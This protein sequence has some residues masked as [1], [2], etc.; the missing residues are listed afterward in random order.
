MSPLGLSIRDSKRLNLCETGSWADSPAPA[1]PKGQIPNG[2]L[3]CV[4]P[5]AYKQG[6]AVVSLHLL[7]YIH[8]EKPRI[9]PLPGSSPWLKVHGDFEVDTVGDVGAGSKSTVAEAELTGPR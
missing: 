5:S 6:A 7:L 8:Y 2:R 3:S 9:G 4:S 1:N